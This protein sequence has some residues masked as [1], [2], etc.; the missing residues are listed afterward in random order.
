MLNIDVAFN[1]LA[2]LFPHYSGCASP[3]NLSSTAFIDTAASK[4]LVTPST[5][6]SPAT[7]LESI[8]VIQPGGDK[9]RT[10]HAVDLLLSKL[11][12]NSR[13]AHS[14]PGLT[15]NLLS[16]AVLCNAGCEVFFNTTGCKVTFDGYIILQG[17]RDSKHCLWHV[18]IVDDAW[19]TNLKI[20]DSITTPQT[21]AVAQS[22]YDCNNMQQLMHFYHTCLFLPVISTLTNAINK[23]YLKGFPGFTAQCVH[24]HV[25]INDA[26]KKEHMDQ[27]HQGQRST[28]PN[29]TNT[30]DTRN[31]FKDNNVLPDHIDEGLT[32]LIFMVIHDITRLVFSNQTSRFPV[33]SNRGHVYLVIFYIYNANFI[34]SV[35][36]KNQTKQELLR[37]YQITYKYLSSCGFKSCL[38]KMDNETSKDVQDFI[39]TQHTTLQYTPPD[40]HCTNS[41]KPDIC[42]RITSLQVS[43]AYQNL[44]HCQLVSPHQPMQLH[45]QHALSLL[46]KSPPL[47]F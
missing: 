11:P 2:N 23:G 41:A 43:P 14:L 20:N 24:C 37:A 7:S 44:P 31:L 6:T 26:T 12:P 33:T 10:T 17:W 40:I 8:T 34:A 46:P 1:I 13:M 3:P 15:N 5:K 28:Q 16:I 21:T 38:H 29:P 32:N 42:T 30:S 22:L 45:N 35:P 19:T 4:S 47:L 25:Q 18:C 9:M 39:Q 36:F 27:T